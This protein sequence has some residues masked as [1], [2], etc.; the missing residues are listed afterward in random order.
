M[1]KSNTD[2]KIPLIGVVYTWRSPLES[3]TEHPKEAITGMAK[4]DKQKKIVFPC[5]IPIYEND[6]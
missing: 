6:Y 1:R 4:I 3:P 5:F 2:H